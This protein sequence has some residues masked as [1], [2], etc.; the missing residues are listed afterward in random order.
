[1]LKKITRI[2]LPRSHCHIPKAKYAF[3]EK[4]ITSAYLCVIEVW[5][6]SAIRTKHALQTSFCI[7][8]MVSATSASLVYLSC[9]VFPFI[10]TMSL[11]MFL[12]ISTCL[13]TFYTIKYYGNMM[14]YSCFKKILKHSNCIFQIN[15]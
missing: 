9:A 5:V 13:Y 6:F 12:H 15:K 8:V 2:T 3:G 14:S 7:S 1:M 11:M 4:S 10:V